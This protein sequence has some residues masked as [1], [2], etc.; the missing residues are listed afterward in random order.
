MVDDEAIGVASVGVVSDHRD[1]GGDRDLD[2]STVHRSTD[3]AGVSGEFPVFATFGFQVQGSGQFTLTVLV[4]DQVDPTCPPI[5]LVDLSVDLGVGLV[6]SVLVGTEKPHVLVGDEPDVSVILEEIDEHLGRPGAGP[7]REVG[8][9]GR[10]ELDLP[11]VGQF[12]PLIQHVVPVV[13]VQGE[14]TLRGVEHLVGDLA[15]AGL[16]ERD[17][18]GQGDEHEQAERLHDVLPSCNQGIPVPRLHGVFRPL[19]TYHIRC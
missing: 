4:R 1:S 6:E 10:E 17:G 15:H 7:A 14:D 12:Q 13:L 5:G 18:G 2:A 3:V 16:R 9:P 11:V 19:A 8:V